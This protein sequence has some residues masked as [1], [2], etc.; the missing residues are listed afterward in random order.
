MGD[1]AG[2]KRDMVAPTAAMAGTECARDFCRRARQPVRPCAA[3]LAGWD[4]PGEAQREQP[5][6]DRPGGLATLVASW[7]GFALWRR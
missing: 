7:K 6:F 2:Q 5:S 3:R 1:S 4:G